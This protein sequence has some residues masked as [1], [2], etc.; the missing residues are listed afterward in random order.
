MKKFQIS[1]RSLLIF[2]IALAA[3]VP[4]I[5]LALIEINVSYKQA[6]ITTENTLKMSTDMQRKNIKNE[7]NSVQAKVNS[8]LI[9]AGQVMTSMGEPYLDKKETITIEAINQMTKQAQTMT[10]PAMK[11]NETRVAFHYTAVDKIRSL[12]GGTATIFQVIPE[13]LL[14]IST[15]VLKTDK[16][17]AVGTY[18]PTDSPVYK[19]VMSGKTFYGRAYVVNAWYI[20]AYKPFKGDDEQIIGVLYVGVKEDSYKKTIFTSLQ[21]L[22]IGKNGY[23]E[24]LDTTGKSVFLSVPP[25]KERGIVSLQT[26]NK[27]KITA[28]LIQRAA[29][30]K[31]GTSNLIFYTTTDPAT[32]KTRKKVT[33]FTYFKPWKW[34]ITASA[35]QDDLVA[36]QIKSDIIRRSIAGGLFILLSIIAAFFIARV[37]STPLKK[38]EDTISRVGKGDLDTEIESSSRIREIAHLTRS[39]GEDLVQNLKRILFGITLS[40]ETSASI[41]KILVSNAMVSSW[42]TG[43]IEKS[44]TGI[45]KEMKTLDEQISEAVSAVTEIHAAVENLTNTTATQSSA[46]SQTSAAIEQMAASIQSIARIAEEKSSTAKVLLD[47]VEEGQ[48]KIAASN[49]HITA[50]DE[51]VK[52]MMEVIG[53]INSIAAQTNLLAM[54]AAIEAAHAG[55]A[56]RGFSVVADEIRKLA[57]STGENAKKISSSLKETTRKMGSAIE[58]GKSSGRSFGKISDE[59]KKFVDAFAEISSSTLEVSGGNREVVKATESLMQ[60]SQEIS[61][62]SSEIKLSTEDISKSLSLLEQSSGKVVGSIEEIQGGTE[63]IRQAQK[64]IDE[65]IRWNNNSLESILEHTRYFKMTVTAQADTLGRDLMNLIFDHSQWVEKAAGIIDGKETITTEEAGNA[66]TCRLGRWID[67]EGQK[68]FN[69]TMAFKELVRNHEL[70]HQTI[71]EINEYMSK[72]ES[73]KAFTAFTSLRAGFHKILGSI[74]ELLSNR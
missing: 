45:H 13:G 70:F 55:D 34:I 12:V 68:I 65:A 74:E 21:N 51:A 27:G 46:V 40:T 59:A 42:F 14:R 24:I 38:A 29:A 2:L 26:I 8:D 9:L 66:H 71:V 31:E 41:G 10:I 23:Y 28:S 64:E 30:M 18:I 50:I 73:A 6:L 5:I 17:R 57:E 52:G 67:T 3:S 15:N 11:M 44:V 49:N 16:K 37:L 56:G 53:V 19:T 69:D 62:G 47:V 33:S 7:F 48:E 61:S 25:D 58:A 39:V 54:N 35:Y 63:Q 72:G 1:F 60:I 4:I 20:T 22:K 43:R 32:G 36:A